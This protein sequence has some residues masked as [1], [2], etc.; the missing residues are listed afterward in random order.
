VP[1]VEEDERRRHRLDSVEPALRI[2]RRRESRVDDFAFKLFLT[3]LGER[4]KRS[5]RR[6]AGAGRKLRRP[7]VRHCEGGSGEKWY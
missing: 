1:E 2:W 7:V 3:S 4:R 6:R 5:A